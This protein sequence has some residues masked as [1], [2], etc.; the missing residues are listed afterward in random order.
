M[1]KD[2]FKHYLEN[3]N[4]VWLFVFK[5]CFEKTCVFKREIIVKRTESP[6]HC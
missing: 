2:G 1:T 6:L 3:D 4:G 5:L